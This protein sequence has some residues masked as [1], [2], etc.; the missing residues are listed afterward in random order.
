MKIHN[1]TEIPNQLLREIIRFV[2]PAGLSNFTVTVRYN[3]RGWHG[4][5]WHGSTRCSVTVHSDWERYPMFYHPYQY[6]QH[7]GRKWWV[8]SWQEMLVIFMAHELRHLWQGKTKNKAGYAWGARG[9][10]SEVDTEAYA[11]RKLREWR[12]SH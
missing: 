8:A 2:R 3:R 5:A 6:G 10:Y 1:T 11:L 4:W 9:R 7:K 12:K